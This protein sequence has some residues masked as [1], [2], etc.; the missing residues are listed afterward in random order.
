MST[1][2]AAGNAEIT[3]DGWPDAKGQANVKEV[4][5]DKNAAAAYLKQTPG[6]Q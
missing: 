1:P 5:G 4:P 6:L 3:D 2:N